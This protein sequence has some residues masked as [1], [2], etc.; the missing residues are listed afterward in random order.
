[1]EQLE[2]PPAEDPLPGFRDPNAR[3][4][5]RAVVFGSSEFAIN[6]LIKQPF[7]NRDVFLNSLNWVTETDQLIQNR[8]YI[9][10]RRTVFLTPQQQNLVFYSSA[11]FYPIILLGIGAFV[12]WTRR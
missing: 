8:P 3:V 9:A 4:K 11:V 2:N 10:E 1:V 12:W 5:N 6:G 7:G